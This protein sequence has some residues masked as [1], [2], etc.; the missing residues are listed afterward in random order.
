MNKLQGDASK[1]NEK[2][3]WKPR[4]S[5]EALVEMMI[6]SDMELAKKEKAI[7]DAGLG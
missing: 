5:F 2:L 1:A 3:G 6:A 7:V 4:L